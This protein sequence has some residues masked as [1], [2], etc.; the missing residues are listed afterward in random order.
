MLKAQRGTEIAQSFNLV[1]EILFFSRL[2]A[3]LATGATQQCFNLVIEI[4][5]FSSIPGISG[6]IC[7]ISFNLV[8]EI[9]F[10]SSMITAA[11]QNARA[12]SFNLVIEILFFSS[13][14]KGHIKKVAKPAFQSRNRDTF[15]F[16]SP[17][18]ESTFLSTIYVSIS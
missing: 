15:L 10:F 16:K 5:F 4:L 12:V 7:W 3:W 17:S 18:R 14:A 8:I 9:L 11:R 6:G 2:E 13:S 1:I